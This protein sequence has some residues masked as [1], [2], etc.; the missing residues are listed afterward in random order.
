[1]ISES[2]VS[3]ERHCTYCGH[4]CHCYSNGCQNCMND[5]CQTCECKEKVNDIQT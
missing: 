5:V 2:K 4:E 3:K 1:M